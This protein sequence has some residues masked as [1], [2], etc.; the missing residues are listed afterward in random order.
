MQ[1]NSLWCL[2]HH[3]KCVLWGLILCPASCCPA[4]D[5]KWGCMLTAICYT[6]SRC[7]GKARCSVPSGIKGA[8]W[9]PIQC[10]QISPLLE[11]QELA[12]PNKPKIILPC[13]LLH[14]Q[15]YPLTPET[16]PT[17]HQRTDSSSGTYPSLPWL[18]PFGRLILMATSPGDEPSLLEVFVTCDLGDL[19]SSPLGSPDRKWLPSLVRM[20]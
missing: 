2:W 1:E 3:Y 15:T 8:Y 5:L 9:I 6:L 16:C 4:N 20:P 7:Y 14:S 13:W 19:L 10:P 18:I 17:M 11:F 12:S